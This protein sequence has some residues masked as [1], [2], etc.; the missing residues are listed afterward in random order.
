MSRRHRGSLG[1]PITANKTIPPSV[2]RLNQTLGALRLLEDNQARLLDTFEDHL[3]ALLA[4]AQG[5]RRYLHVEFYILSYDATTAPFFAALGDAVR[6]HSV[7]PSARAAMRD[8][9]VVGMLVSP[10]IRYRL[11]PR[12]SSART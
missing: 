11:T 5:A 8:T 1:L 10:A 9:T 3:A 12:S 7:S 2:A 6:R 4:A